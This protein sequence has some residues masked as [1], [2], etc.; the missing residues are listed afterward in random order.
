MIVI[1]DIQEMQQWS[2]ARK[3]EGKTIGFVPTM[4]YL[5][6]GHLSLVKAARSKSDV[7]VVSSFVNPTQFAPNED[8]DRYPR[9]FDRD[10]NLLETLGNDVLFFP[11]RNAMYPLD[12]ETFVVTEKMATLW[13]GKTRPTHFRGV[14]TV[15][16]KLMM[17]VQPDKMHMGQKDIQQCAILRRMIIDLNIPVELVIEPIIREIDGLAM[18]SRNVYLNP[19]ERKAALVLSHSI[20]LA[21]QLIQQGEKDAQVII[22]KMKSL[23]E[24]EPLARLDYIALMNMDNLEPVSVIKSPLAIALAVYIGIIRLIDNVIIR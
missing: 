2:T 17:I 22:A 21:E 8:Y 6:S 11:D 1:K 9:D 24:S 19:E 5:H 16:T 10:K 3:K 18:S 13:E 20:F 12:Y 4:G 7:S 14:C 23:I 15:V